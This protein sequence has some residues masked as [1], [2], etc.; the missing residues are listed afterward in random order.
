[1]RRMASPCAS[2]TIRSR[3][4]LT[5]ERSPP[6]REVKKHGRRVDH[7]EYSIYRE[8]RNWKVAVEFWTVDR[9]TGAKVTADGD[10]CI[11]TI[12]ADG[13]VIDYLPGF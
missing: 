8:G 7:A 12:S 1:M 9:V 11:I 13:T 6:R 10:N 3:A 5:T 4:C 2:S